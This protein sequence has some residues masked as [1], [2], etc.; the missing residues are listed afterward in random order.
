[1]NPS[2][3]RRRHLV[4]RVLVGVEMHLGAG[5]DVADQ[6]HDPRARGRA[7]RRA[8]FLRPAAGQ[9]PFQRDVELARIALGRFALEAAGAVLVAVIGR[10]PDPHR[11]GRVGRLGV[12]GFG[13]G[14]RQSFMHLFCHAMQFA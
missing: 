1:L 11:L 13:P 2:R 12:T 3:Q 4:D 9:Q 7:L 6:R 5:G 8:A 10:L 14:L